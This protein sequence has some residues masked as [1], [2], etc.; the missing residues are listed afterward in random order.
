MPQIIDTDLPI[1]PKLNPINTI[2][3]G[4]DISAFQDKAINWPQVKQSM[5]FVYIKATEGINTIDALCKAHANGAYVAGFKIGYYHFA[6]VSKDAVEQARH[7]DN[8]I[9][10]LPAY[11]LPPVVDVETNKADLTPE[12]MEAWISTFINTMNSLNYPVIMIY[13]YCS[14]LNQNLPENHTLGNNPLWIARYS[15]T[16]VSPPLPVGWDR[17]TIWQYTEGGTVNGITG[18]VDMN[19]AVTGFA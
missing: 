13:S 16:L 18:N 1:I 7:F 14:F 19:K 10:S 5:S 9:K 3:L 8:V 12:E 6:L 4:I 17:F 15:N 11:S 2:V